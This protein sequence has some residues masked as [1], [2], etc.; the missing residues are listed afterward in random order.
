M[1]LEAM[2]L[3]WVTFIVVLISS[4]IVS[5]VVASVLGGLLDYGVFG[6]YAAVLSTFSWSEPFDWFLLVSLFAP[7]AI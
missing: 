7:L 4:I 2:R 6:F 5:L 1:G 3:R